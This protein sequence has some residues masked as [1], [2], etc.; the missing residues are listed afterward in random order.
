MNLYNLCTN[1]FH[2]LHFVFRSPKPIMSL[3][4]SAWT[5]VT[6]GLCV[7]IALL[8]GALGRSAHGFPRMGKSRLWTWITWQ[9]PTRF[10]LPR[11]AK[12]GYEQ[13]SDSVVCWTQK[14]TMG[15]STKLWANL[16]SRKFSA[17]TTWFCRPSISMIS[18]ERAHEA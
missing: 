18:S 16:S 12:A 17:T 14:L 7:A 6:V 13:V 5:A 1:H 11:Y 4:S 15:S 10:D 2:I 8:S 3:L 9:K